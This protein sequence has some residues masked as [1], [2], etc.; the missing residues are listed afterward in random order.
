[1]N[2]NYTIFVL[3]L[4]IYLVYVSNKKED[5]KFV[6][7]Y[8]EWCH[9]CKESKPEFQKLSQIK[10]INNKSVKCVAI[11]YEQNNMNENIEG[12]PTFI[13]YVKNKKILYEGNRNFNDFKLFLTQN[14]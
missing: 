10:K 1:M 5:A 2:K 8:A 4:V 7:Y 11:N 9:H 12:Y 6:M 3:L 13:L 14:I